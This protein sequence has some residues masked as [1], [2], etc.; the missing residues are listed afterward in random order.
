MF[1]KTYRPKRKKDFLQND[2]EDGCVILMK[3]QSQ[4][5]TLNTTAAL[6]WVYCDGSHSVERIAE[7][8]ALTCDKEMADVLE[9]VK[10]TILDFQDKGLLVDDAQ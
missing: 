3:E 1:S 10:K 9:D 7:E 4:V 2:L 6:I 5:C 8:L